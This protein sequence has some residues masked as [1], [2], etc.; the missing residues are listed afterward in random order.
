MIVH[1]RRGSA[2]EAGE[3]VTYDLTGGRLEG[4]EGASVSTLLRHI[5]QALDP[6]L[7]YVL[8]CRRGLC[9]VCAVRIDGTT[10]TACTTPAVSGMVIE[11]AKDNLI[12]KDTVA[13]LSLVRRSRIAGTA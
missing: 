8:S 11:A 9:N 3:L 5:Q 2:A 4:W 1:V 7:S 6:S 13:E 10:R 12:L